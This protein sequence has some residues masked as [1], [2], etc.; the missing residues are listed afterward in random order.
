M[1]GRN[2]S[3]ERQGI[4]TRR[5]VRIGAGLMLGLFG[6]SAGMAH[7]ADPV[8]PKKKPA[9]SATTSTITRTGSPNWD[10]V[11]QESSAARQTCQLIQKVSQKPS[12]QLLLVLAVGYTGPNGLPQMIFSIPLGTLL[13]QGVKVQFERQPEVALSVTTCLPAGCIATLNLS[14]AQLAALA[15]G[16]EAR[17]RYAAANG[18]PITLA[19]P[20]T[21]LADALPALRS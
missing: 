8:L 13:T 7:A 19:V 21:G 16:H 18:Q 15:Q 12:G 5:A 2:E 6:L 3:A 17:V 9:A 1:V 4:M 14:P 20:I 11:C 10:R